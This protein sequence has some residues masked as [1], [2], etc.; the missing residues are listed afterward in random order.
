M[1]ANVVN[2]C[3][4]GYKKFC[5]RAGLGDV[6]DGYLALSVRVKDDNAFWKRGKEGQ[7]LLKSWTLPLVE[8]TLKAQLGKAGAK[9]VKKDGLAVAQARVN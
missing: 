2:A 9:N 1:Q 6:R 5:F 7:F 4:N 8:E 3:S